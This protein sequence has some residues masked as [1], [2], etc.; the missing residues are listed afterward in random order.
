MTIVHEDVFKVF[1]NDHMVP[2]NE[3]KVQ[4]DTVAFKYAAMVFEGLRA[5]WN[6]ERQQLFVFRLDDHALRL[7]DSVQVMRM[8][9]I[10]THADFSQAVLRALQSNAVKE[11]VHVRQMVYVD[12]GG[13]MFA[14]GPVSHA[15]IITPKGAWFAGKDAGIHVAVSSWQRITDNSIPPRVKCAANYQ[16]GRLALLQARLDG[17]DGTILLNARGK[18]AEEPRACVFLVR[19]SEVIT[20]QITDDILESITRDTVIR[21]L[22][23]LH[24]IEVIQ[25]DVDRTELYVADE[26]FLCGSGLEITPVL[27]ADRHPIACGNPGKIT[28]A[29]RESYLK[30]VYGE[31]QRYSGWVTPVHPVVNP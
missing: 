24:G 5:Y 13:E 27:S 1:L 12:G 21:L 17:Y 6:E 30:V 18:V 14:R 9:T 25:R 23:D 29:L 3:A 4:I 22:R 31:E 28:M 7:E 16:N 19:N 10:L 20:P 2:K 15:V 11:N 8:E 26:L